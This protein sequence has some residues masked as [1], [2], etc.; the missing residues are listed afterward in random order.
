MGLLDFLPESTNPQEIEERN[1]LEV[2][3]KE[4][5]SNRR[6][7]AR[8]AAVKTFLDKTGQRSDSALTQSS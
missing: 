5:L 6:D 1:Q 8:D 3:L 7:E 4:F 2:F